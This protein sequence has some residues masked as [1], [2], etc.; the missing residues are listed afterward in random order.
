MRLARTG[1]IT[2]LYRAG[3]TRLASTT[4]AVL[5]KKNIQSTALYD[6]KDIAKFR[7]DRA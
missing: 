2:I 5:N 7:R 4:S 1:C 3:D 6:R